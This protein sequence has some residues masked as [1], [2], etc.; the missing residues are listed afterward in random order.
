MA[1]V[2]PRLAAAAVAVLTHARS[3]DAAVSLGISGRTL[4][5]WRALPQFALALTHARREL[6][7]QAVDA[8]RQAGT[9]AVRNLHD[10]LRDPSVAPAVRVQA[11]GLI[12]AHL[13]RAIV[14]SDM[15]EQLDALKNRLEEAESREKRYN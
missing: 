3:E 1:Y 6:V 12:L 5:R 9:D 7:T 15:Q 2:P 10:T 4:R 8:L 13:L 11:S 14:D